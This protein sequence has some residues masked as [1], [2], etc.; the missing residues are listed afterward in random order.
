MYRYLII[1][2]ISFVCGLMPFAAPSYAADGKITAKEWVKLGLAALDQEKYNAAVASFTYALEIEPKNAETY[3]NRALAYTYQAEFEKAIADMNNAIKYSSDEDK[4]GFYTARGLLYQSTGKKT[5]A[6]MDYKKAL[7]YKLADSDKKLCQERLSQLTGEN[8]TTTSDDKG[9]YADKAQASYKNG[10]YQEAIEYSNKAIDNG[11]S[12]GY[13]TRAMTYRATKSYP[14][15]IDDYTTFINTLSDDS[16]ISVVLAERGFAYVK[17]ALSK[18]IDKDKATE[19]VKLGINDYKTAIKKDNTNI[20]A[21]YRL[22]ELFNIFKEYKAAKTILDNLIANN[23][24]AT[25][26]TDVQQLQKEINDNL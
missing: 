14:E 26:D 3:Y 22:A 12:M 13:L 10:N 6:I 23:P 4:G 19:M 7:T 15:A 5:D 20:T 8:T 2:M 11:E 9:K 16:T 24:K 17:Y 1:A 21:S 18:D 25:T